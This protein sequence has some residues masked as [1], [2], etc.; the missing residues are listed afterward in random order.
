[1]SEKK[2]DRVKM[3]VKTFLAI[4]KFIC[5]HFNFATKIPIFFCFSRGKGYFFRQRRKKGEQW[6][7]SQK[8]V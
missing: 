5:V 4:E 1:M 2:T 8:P 7:L 6:R 3:K